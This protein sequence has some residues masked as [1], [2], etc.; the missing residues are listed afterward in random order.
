[1]TDTTPVDLTNCDRE[2]IHIPGSIQTHGALIACDPEIVTV[3]RHSANLGEMLGLDTTDLIGRRLDMVLPPQLVHSLRNGLARSNAA[4]RPGLLADVALGGGEELFDLA[5][6]RHAGNAII[7]IE[8]SVPPGPVSPLEFTRTLVSRLERLGSIEKLVR[9]AAR[10]LRAV[11]QYDRVMIYRFAPDGSGQVVSEAKRADLES[12]LGQ[13]FPAS[14]IPQQARRLYL[15]NPVRVVSDAGGA[16]VVIEPEFDEAGQPLDLSF[17][18]LRSVSPIHCEYLRNMGV[19]ASMSISIILDGQLWGLI[20]CHHYAPRA[21]PMNLRIAAE[22]F[23]EFFSLQLDALIRRETLA[24]AERAR[25]FLDELLEKAPHAADV[26]AFLRGR[27]P[28]FGRLIACDGVGLWLDE[29]WSA[30]GRT[31]PESAM[32]E[33]LAFLG[34]AGGGRVFACH[35]LPARFAS[36]ESYRADA[37]G[38][39]CVPLSQRPRDMLLFFRREVIETVEWGGDPNKQYE[40]GPLGDR[41]TPRKSFAIWKETVERQ[42]KPWSDSDLRAADSTRLALVEVVLH[43]TELLAEERRKADLRQKL[44]NE[45]LNHRVKNILALITSLVSRPVEDDQSIA[46]FVAALKGR[47]VALSVAHDQIVR[48]SGGGLLAALLSAELSPYGG[49]GAIALDGPPVQLD[50]RAYSVLALV[51]HELATN[52]AKYGALSRPG[53]KLSVSW[54]RGDDGGLALSWAES[55]GPPV[56]APTRRG[57]GSVLIGRSV[58]FDLG[59]E[60]EVDYAESGVTARIAIPARHLGWETASAGAAPARAAPSVDEPAPLAGA[61]VLVVEDQFLIAMDVEAMLGEAG[62]ARVETCATVAEAL[63]RLAGF[64]PDVAMLDVQLGTETSEAVARRLVADGIPF[65][66]ASGFSE[67]GLPDG[68]AEVPLIRK[69]Y[70]APAVI[71][72]MARLLGRTTASP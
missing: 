61:N 46:G 7:E 38:V 42:S 23:G 24:A 22:I 48:G 19:G 3:R 41:L 15:Q 4:S 55:G 62:A 32:P 68:L 47:I 31:P 60:A 34:E 8:R 1:M 66:F 57:F 14:D 25:A 36:A 54:R 9:Q 28:D 18:H 12:F 33:L 26:S 40:T 70:G 39:L 29:A 45:E 69:P 35:D 43:H 67:A 27:L 37:A 10:L 51:L 72:T 65:A 52:A 64:R 56:V 59:G 30:T 16:R 5:V 2:P 71:G 17:A 20:A 21:L 6:H 53:G 44:L 58:P 11:L 63:A 13:H 49:E 50:G